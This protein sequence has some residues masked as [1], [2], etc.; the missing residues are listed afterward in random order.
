MKLT[1]GVYE[2]YLFKTRDGVAAR[3][4]NLDM[5][6]EQEQRTQYANE[7]QAPPS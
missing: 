6:V 2:D 3:K 4:R 1:H 7:L 5:V